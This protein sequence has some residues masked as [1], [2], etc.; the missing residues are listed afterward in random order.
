MLLHEIY[1]IYFEASSVEIIQTA[2]IGGEGE[3]QFVGIEGLIFAAAVLVQ[4]AV[5]SV[6]QQGMARVGELSTNLVGTAGDQLALHKTQ[7]IGGSENLVIGLAGL[8]T[9]LRFVGN[10]NLVVLGIL[11]QVAF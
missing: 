7:P 11:E 9:G 4:L 2:G 5:L 8:G 10:E 3:G 1:F 6:A